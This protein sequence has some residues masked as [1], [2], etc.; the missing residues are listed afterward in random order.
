MR[1]LRRNNMK[2]A[3]YSRVSTEE[4]V[5]GF[6]LSAQQRGIREFCVGKGWAVP[7]EYV[8]EGRSARSDA[9]DK[10]P[11]LRDLLEACHQ[12]RY[13]VVVVYSLDR[14]ARNL[15]VTLQTFGALAK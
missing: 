9:I 7:D 12:Q 6:S 14:W 8:D 15:M 5:E 13:E 11:A 10:R 2:V 1:R 3:S 4:Q